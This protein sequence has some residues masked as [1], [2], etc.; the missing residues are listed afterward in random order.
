MGEMGAGPLA[1][2]LKINST[3]KTL[4]LGCLHIVLTKTKQCKMKS[5]FVFIVFFKGTKSKEQMLHN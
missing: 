5:H 1:E 2:I 4:S 3:L